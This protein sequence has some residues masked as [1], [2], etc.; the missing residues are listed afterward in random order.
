MQWCGAATVV[1]RALAGERGH[2]RH[3]GFAWVLKKVYH[4]SSRAMFV[5][6]ACPGSGVGFRDPPTFPGSK[7]CEKSEGCEAE[8]KKAYFSQGRTACQKACWQ[9]WRVAR[10]VW[11]RSEQ[12]YYDDARPTTPHGPGVRSPCMCYVIAA[13]KL[14]NRPSALHGEVVCAAGHPRSQS[15]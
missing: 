2:G 7:R 1:C 11:S 6:R 15:A 4:P 3:G 9:G 8:L 5:R 13:S 10:L 12:K 14:H